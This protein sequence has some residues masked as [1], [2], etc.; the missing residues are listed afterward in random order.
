MPD[1]G[2][3]RMQYNNTETTY[4]QNERMWQNLF[5]IEATSIKSVLQRSCSTTPY[6]RDALVHSETL[7]RT[8]G[9]HFLHTGTYP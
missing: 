7:E 9:T 4:R 5:Y 1:S 3:T 2:E 8:A 6:T